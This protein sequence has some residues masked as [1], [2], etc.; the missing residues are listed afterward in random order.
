LI[1]A[2]LLSPHKQVKLQHRRGFQAQTGC[3]GAP[4]LE[5]QFSVI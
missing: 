2:A 1:I 3:E 4:V 5:F